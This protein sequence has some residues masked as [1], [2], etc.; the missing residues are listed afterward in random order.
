MNTFEL[1]NNGFNCLFAPEKLSLGIGVPI[2]NYATGAIPTMENHLQ[3]AQLVEQLGFKALWIRDVPFHVPSF[4]DVGQMYEPF[5]YLGF[6]AAHTTEIALGIGSIALPL[7][8]PAHIAKA[9]ATVDQL[10]D[11]RFIMGVASGDRPDEYPAM[12]IQHDERGQLFRESFA[13]IR[14]THERFPA[15]E[16][17][18]FGVLDGSIDLL[19][20]PTGRKIPMLITGHSQQSLEWNAEHGDGW[21]NYPKG[22]YQ[23]EMSMKEWRALLATTQPYDKPYLQSLFIDLQTNDNFKPEPIPLGFRIGTNPLISHLKLL[24]EMGVN[25]VVLVLRFNEADIAETIKRLSNDVLPAFH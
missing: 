13:Y 15:L 14:K 1:I 2:E 17:N 9:A 20:K 10:S 18:Q 22:N 21:L 3:R 25:H 23:Q 4:G 12:N 24:Q 6:L 7:H 11:G 19:P 16:Q 5:T 8:H